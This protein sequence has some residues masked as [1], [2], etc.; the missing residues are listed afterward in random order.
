MMDKKLAVKFPVDRYPTLRHIR[1][2]HPFFRRMLDIH[3]Q[4]GWS[5]HLDSDMLFFINPKQITDAFEKKT[6]IYMMEQLKHSYFADDCKILKDKYD[7][8]CIQLVNGG[9]IAYNNDLVDYDDLEKKAAILINAYP[10]AGAAQ[11]E[12]TLMS[13]IL[14][15]QNAVALDKDLYKIN[16]DSTLSDNGNEVVKHYIFKAKLPYFKSEWKKVL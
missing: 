16:Y 14:F 8:D 15:K 13:H 9:I 11:I 4:P 7:I 1:Q 5:I 12:Q 2:W 10:N 6:A 3:T